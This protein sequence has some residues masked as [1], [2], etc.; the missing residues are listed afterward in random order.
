LWRLCPVLKIPGVGVVVAKHADV[1]T[2]LE[3]DAEFKPVYLQTS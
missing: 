1:M 3:R 2:V